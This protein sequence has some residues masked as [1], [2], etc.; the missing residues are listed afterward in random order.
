M[1]LVPFDALLTRSPE[2]PVTFRKLPYLLNRYR[3]SYSPSISLSA[4][5]DIEE[6]REYRQK[7]LAYAPVFSDLS[8]SQAQ[9]V[10]NRRGWESLPSTKYE[11]EEIVS[12]LNE[13][14]G[15]WSSLTGGERSEALT[16][17]RATEANFKSGALS[18]Y[19]YLHLATHA[20]TSDAGQQRSGI[21]FFPGG[22]GEEDGI[23]YAEEIY[24]LD[25]NNELVVLS[26]CETGTGEVRA[27]EGIIGLSR[28]F[29][30]AGARSLLVSLWNVE[31]RSTAQL[32]IAFY[33]QLQA[34][35]SKASA[36]KSA[37]H[38]LIR[39]GSYAHPRYWA[40]FVFIGE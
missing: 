37:K 29:Q 32:M 15:F 20:F 38:S 12:Y 24:G 14:R 27:G 17:H 39:S 9:Q 23:L 36:L 10:S 18:N 2:E 6:E 8:Q 22:T 35:E 4:Y 5:L 7:L 34:G 26:A 25:L 3:F 16:G 21:A 33:E 31:D 28:A 30:Y 19:R 13:E 11:V 1:N 40:P